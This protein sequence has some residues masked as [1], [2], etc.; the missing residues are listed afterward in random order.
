MASENILGLLKQLKTIDGFKKHHPAICNSTNGDLIAYYYDYW[1]Y[2]WGIAVFT[3]EPQATPANTE[4]GIRLMKYDSISSVFM[5][6]ELSSKI[7]IANI[8]SV[9]PSSND[10]DNLVLSIFNS[11]K[12]GDIN[13]GLQYKGLHF[14]CG[15]WFD[16]IDIKEIANGIVKFI[17]NHVD[18][19]GTG[20]R[21]KTTLTEL[22]T[23]CQISIPVRDY[24]R[25]KPVFDIVNAEAGLLKGVVDCWKTTNISW[26]TLWIPKSE[27]GPMQ[28][29]Y[30]YGSIIRRFNSDTNKSEN[31][32]STVD[33]NISDPLTDSEKWLKIDDSKNSTGA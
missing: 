16:V 12:N 3:I 30:K 14:D 2:S 22:S 1:V 17:S 10:W 11:A 20:V 4:Y 31:Y 13:Y 7:D 29:G 15:N 23:V 8:E 18:I 27:Y 24:F 28:L 32:I 26:S 6:D 21:P 9:K 5:D 33:E 25:V 19:S